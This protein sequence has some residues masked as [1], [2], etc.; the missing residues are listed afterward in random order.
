MACNKI[1]IEP[2]SKANG[3]NGFYLWSPV[4]IWMYMHPVS[5]VNRERFRAAA[6]FLALEEMLEMPGA[7]HMPTFMLWESG[8]WQSNQP[9]Y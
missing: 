2:V 9:A 4:K 7:T 5:L 1:P 8:H 6:Q 3:L